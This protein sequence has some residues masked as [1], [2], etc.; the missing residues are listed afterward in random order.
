LDKFAGDLRTTHPHF[1]YTPHG[2]HAGAP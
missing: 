2:E 1:E